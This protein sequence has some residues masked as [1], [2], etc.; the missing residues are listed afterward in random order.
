MGKKGSWFAAVRNIFKSSSKDSAK[1]KAFATQYNGEREADEMGTTKT[2]VYKDKGRWSFGKSKHVQH[3]EVVDPSN[4][5][6][7]ISMKV[8]VDQ[9]KHAL[10][11]AAASAAAAE[12]AVAAAY[13]AAEVVRLTGGARSPS[14]A[15]LNRHLIDGAHFSSP[16]SLKEEDW[17]AIKIQ[18]AFRG[19]LARRALRAL[20][21]LVR[22]Q[23][24]VRGHAVRRQAT[25]TFR[26]MQ[27]LVRIQ[28]RVRAMHMRMPSD[29][30][31]VQWQLLH[32]NQ[33]E[34]SD[35]NEELCDGWDASVQ[36]VEEKVF[37]RLHKKEAAL[38]R[39][40][41]LAY[42]VSHQSWRCSP[43]PASSLC[44]D[45]E[46]EERHW[47]WTWLERW[48]AARSWEAPQFDSFASDNIFDQPKVNPPAFDLNTPRK[49][50]TKTPV[51]A[52]G[53]NV[54]AHDRAV[55]EC[56]PMAMT[57]QRQ[58]LLLGSNAE[59][60]SLPFTGA[61]ELS[62]CSLGRNF[63]DLR[64]GRAGFSVADDDSGVSSP[65]LPNYMA[66]THS[67]KAKARLRSLSTPKQR[68]VTPEREYLLKSSIRKRL[69]F[70]ATEGSIGSAMSTPQHPRAFGFTERSPSVKCFPVSVEADRYVASYA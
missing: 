8:E 44:T 46:F 38:R 61:S 39:E 17:A 30:Q 23:A 25:R 16:V 45:H 20:K 32:R 68:T 37:R 26:C 50:V 67:A 52:N 42:A 70:P 28:A 24:L 11:V 64:S 7:R 36:S 35:F 14:L 27:A 6:R 4:T 56:L 60:G 19:Y 21:G 31:G 55:E 47:G 59:V 66:S 18:T 29:G 62:A 69:S 1:I 41:A 9:D 49:S 53:G 3:P 40:R 22:L 13:A 63:G 34:L 54:K 2:K 33:Q 10:A 65:C 58:S 43:Q 15:T 12:A 51:V 57:P 5:E 48:M